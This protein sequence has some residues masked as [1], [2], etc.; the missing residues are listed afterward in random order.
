M[1]K[2]ISELPED[3]SP[4]DTSVVPMVEAGVTVRTTWANIKAFLKTWL[5][6]TDLLTIIT[7]N[8]GYKTYTIR[9]TGTTASSEGGAVT[10]A[11]GVTVGKIISVTSLVWVSTSNAIT[12]SHTWD[13]GRQYDISVAGPS[14][15]V[16]NHATNSENILSKPFTIWLTYEA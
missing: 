7:N 13:V 1:G 11:H 14:V 3:T 4:L 5:D 6:G 12:S 10:V 2:R 15:Y 16:L 8:S 9:L